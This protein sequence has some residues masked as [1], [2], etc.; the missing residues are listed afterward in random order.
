MNEHLRRR[1]LLAASERLDAAQDWLH[2]QHILRYPRDL[3]RIR[4]AVYEL[5]LARPASA[6]DP[7]MLPIRKAAQDL[8]RMSGLREVV[9]R[10]RA[11]HG[12]VSRRAAE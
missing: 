11:L 12:W 10:C 2:A 1:G 4:D 9:A 3:R 7:E 6:F 8:T 5:D